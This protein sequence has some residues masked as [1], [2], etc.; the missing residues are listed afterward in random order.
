MVALFP[1]PFSSGER[2]L[3]AMIK[4]ILEKKYDVT[5]I[6]FSADKLSSFAFSFGKI[7]NQFTSLWLFGKAVSK[8]KKLIKE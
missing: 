4:N 5:A 6:N 7:K 3:N 2:M 1:P 8:V